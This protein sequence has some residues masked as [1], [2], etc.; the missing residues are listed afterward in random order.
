MF[1]LSQLSEVVVGELAYRLICG[2]AQTVNDKTGPG[3]MP[4]MSA[5]AGSVAPT[6]TTEDTDHDALEMQLMQQSGR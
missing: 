2:N 1:L 3:C 4:R 6:G 5:K